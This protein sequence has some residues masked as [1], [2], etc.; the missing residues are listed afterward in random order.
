LTYVKLDASPHT[1]D[2]SADTKARQPDF[3]EM[4]SFQE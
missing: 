2:W 4:A 3:R 1:S